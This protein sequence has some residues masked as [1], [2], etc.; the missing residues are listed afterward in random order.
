LTVVSEYLEPYLGNPLALPAD[1]EA[2]AESLSLQKLFVKNS[3][4]HL[5][6]VPDG[7]RL[8]MR[9]FAHTLRNRDF[10]AM[11]RLSLLPPLASLGVL[12]YAVT[13]NSG[14]IW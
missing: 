3:V 10:A 6:M 12:A 2:T 4:L 8:F 1:V 11:A 5:P 13:G 7:M 14:R 9:R